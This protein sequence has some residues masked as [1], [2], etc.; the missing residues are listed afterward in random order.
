MK[1][2]TKILFSILMTTLAVGLVSCGASTPTAVVKN[3]FKQINSGEFIQDSITTDPSVEA[4]ESFD[5]A[6]KLLL[7]SYK[8]LKFTINDST[9]NGDTATVN[10]TV[11]GPNIGEVLKNTFMNSFKNV[12]ISSFSGQTLSDTDS[13]ILLNTSLIESFNN[14]TFEE[15]TQDIILTKV[16]KE[17]TIEANENLNKLILGEPNLTTDQS[18]K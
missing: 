14:L 9:I 11:S 4:K 18:S 13:E 15:R 10:T 2:T 3:Y 12:L 8:D 5:E 7:D 16:D 6:N 1:K 17:W